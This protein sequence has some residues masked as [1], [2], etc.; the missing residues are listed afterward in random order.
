MA[1]YMNTASQI[2]IDG[3]S[4]IKTTGDVTIYTTDGNDKIQL[5]KRQAAKNGM[6]APVEITID[7]TANITSQN[8]LAFKIVEKRAEIEASGAITV[9]AKGVTTVKFQN[10]EG[11]VF[12]NTVFIDLPSNISITADEYQNV[13][14]TSAAELPFKTK[15]SRRDIAALIFTAFAGLGT[16]T[17]LLFYFFFTPTQTFTMLNLVRQ[18]GVLLCGVL[19]F[20]FVLATMHAKDEKSERHYKLYAAALAFFTLTLQTLQ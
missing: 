13:E 14:S 2:K 15:P 19:T 9:T 4:T 11:A 7:T 20:V 10:G 3:T 12:T 6:Q 18:I 1:T 8:R 17:L 16:A 5:L